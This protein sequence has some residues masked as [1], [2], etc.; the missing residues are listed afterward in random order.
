MTVAKISN[1]TSVLQHSSA[2][3]VQPQFGRRAY[4]SHRRMS[5]KTVV[6]NIVESIITHRQQ[7]QDR[8]IG[9]YT[10]DPETQALVQ[11]ELDALVMAFDETAQ[12][13]L[14]S[15]DLVPHSLTNL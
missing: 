11:A 10:H 14:N 13:M 4:G 6:R 8:P 12:A 2:L 3:P 1:S 5:Q 7:G 15:V 9:Q